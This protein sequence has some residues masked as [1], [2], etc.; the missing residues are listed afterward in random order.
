[1]PSKLYYGWWI[2]LSG[3]VNQAIAGALSQRSYGAYVVLLRE[4]FGW[5]KAALSGAFSLQQIESGLIGPIQG[6][7]LDRFG[8]RLSMRVGIVL[9]GA[10][11]MLFSQIHSLTGFY[12]SYLLMAV[13]TSLSSYFPLSVVI[14]NWFDRRRARALSAIQMGSAVGGLL[15][16]VVAFSL[17]TY[18][19]RSTAFV[20]G[21]LLIVVGLPLTQVIRRRP[22]DHGLSVDGEGAGATP[23]GASLA[24]AGATAR[25]F[26]LRQAMATPAFW[27]ISLGHGSALLI[28]SAV[29]V[30]LVLHLT[31]DL[32]YSLA[33]ASLVVTAITASQIGG[34]LL[35]GAIGDK[36][37]KRLLSVAC[38]GC[39]TLGLLLVA[40]AVNIV[41]VFT[42]A[43][44]H[45][46]AWGLRGPMM[47]AIRADYFGRSA[48]GAILGTS[49]LVVTLGSIAGP[50][51]AGYLADQTGGYNIGFTVLALLSGL[52]SV[53]FLLAKRPSPP[54][55]A[56][57]VDTQLAA[58][59]ERR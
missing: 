12:I 17:E 59:P 44:L 37:D 36:F 30:H 51:V 46:A 2:V 42:F 11:F 33:L 40:N 26:T 53:F 32:D 22:E 34:T 23:P 47:Q 27:L 4:E 9:F 19:W 21:V 14:V 5:S 25:D 7:L 10:G 35:G 58:I 49:S 8:P 16:A 41:M 31:E 20:S 57:V 54:V 3:F 1:M 43:I 38:M 56:I 52:G 13:G 28:V 50:L 55:D 45:G 29:N 39:H 48:Y 15:V 24:E 6:W 18:G